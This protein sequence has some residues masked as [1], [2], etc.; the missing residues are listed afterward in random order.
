MSEVFIANRTI[1]NGAQIPEGV[2]NETT[3][4]RTGAINTY[5]VTFMTQRIFIFIIKKELY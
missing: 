4:A 3:N 1:Q 5:T 2:W